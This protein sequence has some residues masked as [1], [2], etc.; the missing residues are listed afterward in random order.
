VA[1]V[2]KLHG[3]YKLNNNAQVASKQWWAAIM[4]NL[5]VKGIVQR[6]LRWVEIDI[7]RQVLLQCWGAG[8][9]FLT[10]KGHH[11]GFYKKHFAAT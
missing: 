9:S 7:N 2:L 4:D 10:L 6:K 8:H 5:S 3:V 1:V 11:L